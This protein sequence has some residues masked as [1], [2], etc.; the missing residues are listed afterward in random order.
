[1]TFKIG[2]LNLTLSNYS[3]EMKLADIN[4]EV[5]N[6]ITNI[7][8]EMQ[9]MKDSNILSNSITDYKDSNIEYI[10]Y[11]REYNSLKN[12]YLI[13]NVSLTTDGIE[14]LRAEIEEKTGKILYYISNSKC[15]IRED[16]DDEEILRNYIKYLDL[17]II[18]DWKYENNILISEKARLMACLTKYS[19]DYNTYVLAIYSTNNEYIRD[20]YDLRN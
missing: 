10:V 2:G 8:R 5:D 20:R 4:S 19:H 13:N 14:V 3:S 1:M 16:I 12:G 6:D 11:G 15:N 7:N 18:D 17:Y 9:K